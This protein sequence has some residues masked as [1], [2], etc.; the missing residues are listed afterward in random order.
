MYLAADD[1]QAALAT[2]AACSFVQMRLR[3]L[4]EL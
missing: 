1:W 3:M 4:T 2:P